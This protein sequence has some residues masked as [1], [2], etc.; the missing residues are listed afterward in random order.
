MTK[1]NRPLFRDGRPHIQN[2]TWGIWTCFTPNV[3]GYGYSAEGAFDDW[4]EK[5]K[6]FNSGNAA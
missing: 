4:Q 1:Q 6:I 2:L 3:H 5:Q